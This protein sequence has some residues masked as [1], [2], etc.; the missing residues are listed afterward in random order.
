MICNGIDTDQLTAFAAMASAGPDATS[1]A[2]RVRT[3]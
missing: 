3:R 2:A 1:L